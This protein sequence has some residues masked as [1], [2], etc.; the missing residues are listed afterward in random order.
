MWVPSFANAWQMRCPRPPLPPV[1]NATA[2]L[3]S[4][5]FLPPVST[6]SLRPDLRSG[7]P[8]TGRAQQRFWQKGWG[9]TGGMQTYDYIVVGAGSAG[10]VVANRLSANPR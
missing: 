9:E 10:A 2:P 6:L 3:N 4:I 8:L 1:T 5:D 7:N